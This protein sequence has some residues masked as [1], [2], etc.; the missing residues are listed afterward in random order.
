MSARL[1]AGLAAVALGIAGTPVAAQTYP[2]Q[3]IKF[4]VPLAPGGVG[5]VL[6]R[7]LAA[8]LT[9]NGKT[10]I[11]ENVTGAG[12]AIGANAVAKAAPDGHI[13]LVGFHGTQSILRHLSK[14]QY[15][16]DKDFTPVI[17]IATSPNVLVV[18]PSVPVRSVQELV[19]YA[20]A[21]PGQLTFASQ[22]VGSSGHMAG[23]Q[24]KQIAGIDIRHV[25]Y[26]GA[27]PAGQDLV[28]GH[29]SM[30]FDIVPLAKEQVEAGR[31]RAL[32]V[33]GPKRIAALPQVPTTAEE[34]IA[35]LEGGPWFG[36]L[37]PAGTPRAIID[38]LNAEA[39]KVFS[40]PDISGRLAA[41][42]LVLQTGTPED[43]AAHIAAETK[44]WGDVIDRA[45][46]KRSQ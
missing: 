5:D 33:T 42:G 41:Q 2:T 35:G 1:V 24:L 4:V 22:G 36:L 29:V 45:G 23:E 16:P 40:T 28:G 37:V 32:A 10:A 21:N 26:R 46:I 25:P 8:K 12:G 15:D 3:T 13:V 14:L 9:E 39:R 27:A 34:G 43:F 20:K 38:W 7:T 6:A 19:A 44:R 31:L 18:H 17:L 11:V 30:M